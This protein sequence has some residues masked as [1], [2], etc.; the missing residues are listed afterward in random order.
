VHEGL[1]TMTTQ[2]TFKRRVRAR[3]TKTGES[4]AAARAQLLRKAEP[5]APSPAAHEVD[6]MMLTGMS[7]DAMRRGSGRT[8]GEWLAILDAWGAGQHRHPDIVRWLVGEHGIGGWWAQSVTVGYERAR[9]IRT[10]NQRPDGYTVSVTKT[11][12][13]TGERITDA[14]TVDTIRERWLHGAPIRHRTSQRGRSGRFDWGDPPSRIGLFLSPRG[15]GRT[16]LSVQF[17]KLPDAAAVERIRATWREYL[18]ALK[19]V[20]EAE[21]PG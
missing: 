5:A 17:E 14:F 15:D 21:P 8:I 9:G 11:I 1:E 7:D 12:R 2:K 3:S 19:D 16:Q 6:P 4:Y 13:A 10:L 20:L 18:A